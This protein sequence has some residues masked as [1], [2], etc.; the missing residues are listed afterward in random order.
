MKDMGLKNY[1]HRVSLGADLGAT[2]CALRI[3][4]I[5]IYMYICKIA[6]GF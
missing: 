5:Y 4:E 3:Q 6:V 1:L 2:A